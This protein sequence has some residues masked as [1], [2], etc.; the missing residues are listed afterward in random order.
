MGKVNPSISD[1]FI[2]SFTNFNKPLVY[3]IL[4]NCYYLR[5]HVF[6]LLLGMSVALDSTNQLTDRICENHRIR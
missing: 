5:N 6:P 4:K 1:I 2:Y 3:I